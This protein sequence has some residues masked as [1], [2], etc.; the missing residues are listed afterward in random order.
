MKNILFLIAVL[1]SVNVLAQSPY[2]R[3]SDTRTLTPDRVL[4]ERKS[5]AAD[6]RLGATLNRGNVNLLYLSGNASIAKRWESTAL[7]VAGTGIYNTFGAREVLNQVSTVIRGDRWI[8]ESSRV[9]VF[10]THGYNRSTLIDYRGSVGVGPWHDFNLG[11]T[12]HGLSVAALF[13]HE[14][15]RDGTRESTPRGSL[16]WVSQIPLT[17]MAYL[18]VD[19]FYA[20]AIPQL[21]D[22]RLYSEV[23]FETLFYKDVLGLKLSWTDEFDSRPKPGVERNDMVWL[24]SFTYHFGQ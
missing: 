23:S 13:E 7:Y 14:R 10:T 19:F 8:A 22:V 2:L 1:S 4:L 21:A 6:G 15:F 17:D 12:R 24:A 20:P 11:P 18:G 3:A 9:F 16:R 5:W